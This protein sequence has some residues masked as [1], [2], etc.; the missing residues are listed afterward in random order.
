MATC[1]STGATPP[2]WPLTRLTDLSFDADAAHG[3]DPFLVAEAIAA[4]VE[5]R[6][7]VLVIDDL[8][9][10]DADT[11]RTVTHLAAALRAFGASSCSPADRLGPDAGPE[12]VSCVAEVT[13]HGRLQIELHPLR[14]L[15]RSAR[16]VAGASRRPARIS[17]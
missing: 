11:L 17:P 10:A 7:T 12:L 6:P 2:F 4:S 8:Q 9:W 14:C 13:R 16:W 15:T 5:D 3:G 1:P